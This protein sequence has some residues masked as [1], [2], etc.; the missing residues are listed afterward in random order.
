[1][2]GNTI[3]NNIVALNIVVNDNFV[4]II[5][6]AANSST[7]AKVSFTKSFPNISKIKVFTGENFNSWQKS[8]FSV[9]DMYGVAWVFNDLKT[10]E[11][12]KACIHRNKVCT[13]FFLNTLSNELFDVYCSYKKVYDI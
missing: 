2:D 11:N 8:I 9:L 6:C 1:M 12:V 5:S 13:H 10:S 3:A 7:I 4:D